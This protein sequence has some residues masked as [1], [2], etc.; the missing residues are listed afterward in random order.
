VIDQR[1]TSAGARQVQLAAFRRLTPSERALAALQMS[2]EARA[3]AASGIRQRSPHAAQ[4][5]IDAALRRLLLGPE[6]AERVE[7][8]RQERCV[9]LGE[10]LA[11]LG[12]GDVWVTVQRAL[13]ERG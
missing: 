7:R 4:A 12:L 9:T 3:L 1:D 5:E 6:L 2:E 8:A 13:E 11:R 10:L